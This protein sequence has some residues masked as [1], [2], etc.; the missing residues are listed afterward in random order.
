MAL[1]FSAS[2]SSYHQHITQCLAHGKQVLNK[3]AGLNPLLCFSQRR[4]PSS[5]LLR[6]PYPTSPYKEKGDISPLLIIQ[7]TSHLD[8]SWPS[9]H[10]PSQQASPRSQ[11]CKRVIAF[12]ILLRTAA[13]WWLTMEESAERIETLWLVQGARNG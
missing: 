7:G 9:S 4:M 13:L 12:F 6:P 1:I 10:L 11:G 2:T 8:H 5:H 3:I